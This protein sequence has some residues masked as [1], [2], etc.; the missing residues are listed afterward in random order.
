[1]P[2]KRI[3][4][5]IA[6]FAVFALGAYGYLTIEHYGL[7]N[8]ISLVSIYGVAGIIFAESGL[9][10]GFFLP[11]DSLL[12]TVGFL[13]YQGIINFN[14]HL[15][16]LIFFIA[17]IL[18]DSV[19][20]AFGHKVGRRLFQRKDSVLFHRENLERA[21]QFYERHGGKAIILARFMPVIRTFAPIVAGIS[22]MQYRRFLMFNVIGAL[23]WA[24]GVTYLGYYAGRWIEAAGI[25]IEYVIIFIILISI[26]PPFIHV[27][28]EKKNR[29]A[30]YNAIKQQLQAFFSD[31]KK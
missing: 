24:V 10:V 30:F 14:I 16:V 20:Y 19:G 1:M 25:N 23:L 11:G 26:L 5:L 13:I 31:D 15:A 4:A 12:F 2:I 7:Q 18:G 8:L 6:F 22:R 29:V 3:F 27:F 17:A 9:L 28:K 21:E